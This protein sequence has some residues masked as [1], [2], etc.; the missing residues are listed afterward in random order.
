LIVVI[1]S[2]VFILTIY[3]NV[4][5]QQTNENP[6][7]FAFKWG[8]NGTGNGQFILPHGIDFD[9][10]GN[11]Y[12]TDRER[13]DI[14]KFTSN[15]KFIRSGVTKVKVM[16]SLELHIPLSSINMTMFMLLKGITIVFKNLMAMVTLYKSGRNSMPRVPT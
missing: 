14:Q 6:Y 7:A 3:P 12:V 5:A 9:S 8:S 4:F 1:L 10:K 13:N 11:V 2:A 15:G 16:E